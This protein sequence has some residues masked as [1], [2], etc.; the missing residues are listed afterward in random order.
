MRTTLNLPE[1]LLKEAMKVTQSRTKTD[2]ITLALRNL[3]RQQ[4]L[5]E[6]KDYFGKVDL[7]VDLD[8]LR[9]R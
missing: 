7:D 8:S 4:K 9:K 5:T 6:L 3:V 2:V 1:D